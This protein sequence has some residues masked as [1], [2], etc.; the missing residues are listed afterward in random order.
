VKA[1]VEDAVTVATVVA[2]AATAV[3]AADATAIN[4]LVEK[5]LEEEKSRD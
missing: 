5:I 1:A 2:V 4:Q 3:A